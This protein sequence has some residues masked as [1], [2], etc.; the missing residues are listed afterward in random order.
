MSLKTIV[1]YELSHVYG[2]DENDE[3]EVF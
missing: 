3:L 2:Y 1:V